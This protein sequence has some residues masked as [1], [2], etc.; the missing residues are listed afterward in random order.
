MAKA[1]ATQSALDMIRANHGSSIVF[2]GNENVTFNVNATSTG[3]LN[4][5]D[6]IGCGGLPDGRLILWSGPESSGKTLGSLC[7]AKKKQGQKKRFLFIDAEATWDNTW[8]Q[9]LGIRTDPEWCMISPESSGSKIFDL[10]CGKPA[11]KKRKNAIPGILSDEII[12]KMEQEGTPLGAIIVDSINMVAPPLEQDMESGEQQIGSLSRFLPPMLRRLTPLLSRY[13]IPCIF[14]CQARTNIG[15]MHGDPLTVSGGKAL[16]HAA[17]LWIDSRKIGGSEIYA[18][19][20]KDNEKPIGHQVRCKVRKNKVGPPGRKSE[21]TIY[22]SKGID[23]RPELV[24]QGIARGILRLEGNTIYYSGFPGGKIIHKTNAVAALYQD[25]KLAKQLLSD[26]LAHRD[27]TLREQKKAIAEYIEQEPEDVI[28]GKVT[29]QNIEEEGKAQFVAGGEVQSHI[30]V[31]ADGKRVDTLTGEILSVPLKEESSPIRDEEPQDDPEAGVTTFTSD[32]DDDAT[33]IVIP[34]EETLPEETAP[35][36]SSKP[37][38]KGE[39]ISITYLKKLAQDKKIPGWYKLS[40]E[41]LIAALD[42]VK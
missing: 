29:V 36:L 38:A 4:L 18:A 31:Q 8:A 5:D 30:K 2:G 3:S 15:Q 37:L 14:I 33:G 26:I 41:D 11:S 27:N 40:R 6:S 10:L 16:M 23:V 34:V 35:T 22:Y 17:S 19:D 20:D 25:T 13:E 9:S 28:Q 7:Y 42:K 24:D 1:P 32:E 21:L 39:E 12:K